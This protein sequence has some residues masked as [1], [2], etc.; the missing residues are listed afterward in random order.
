MNTDVMLILKEKAKTMGGL[1]GILLTGVIA[2]GGWLVAQER[3]LAH[4][5]MNSDTQREMLINI[6]HKLDAQSEKVDRRLD[7]QSRD[8]LDF[9]RNVYEHLGDVPRARRTQRRMDEVDESDAGT[10]AGKGDVALLGKPKPGSG[11]APN[12]EVNR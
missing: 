12:T 6:D 8:F 4:V 10:A 1:G 9:A 11:P 3:R 2:A 7:R 5:E